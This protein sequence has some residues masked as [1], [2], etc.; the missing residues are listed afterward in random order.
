MQVRGAGQNEHRVSEVPSSIAEK[1][2]N[3]TM[4]LLK[5]AEQL[6]HNKVKWNSMEGSKMECLPGAFKMS[7]VPYQHSIPV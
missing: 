7:E 3:K 2:Q 1:L 4:H 6:Q 5:R